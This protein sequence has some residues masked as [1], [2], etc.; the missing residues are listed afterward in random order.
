MGKGGKTNRASP[1]FPSIGIDP[2]ERRA[3]IAEALI[4]G[5]PADAVIAALA[6]DGMSPAAARYEVEKAEKSP[7]LRAGRRAA[8]RLAKRDWTLAIYRRLA[9]TDPA[10][11]TITV[12][13]RIDPARFYADFYHANRPVKL[14]GLISDW[15]ALE[16]WTLDG[17]EARLGH[18]PITLQDRRESSD[19]YELDKDA[20][21]NRVP[22]ADII[23]RLRAGASNDFYVTAYNDGANK[24]VLAPL[25]EDVQPISLLAPTGGLD[26]FFWMGPKGTITP[27]HHD[28]T[29]N[30][31]LQISG[32]KR[33]KMVAAHDG[34]MM[35]NSLHCFSDW[36]GEELPAG[37]GDPARPTV[38]ECDI[39]PG[40]ALFLPV[41]WW[42]HV[43]GLDVTIGMS[44]TNFAAD[45]DFYSDYRTYGPL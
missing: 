28:L 12:V 16:R 33:V 6:A 15:P 8:E 37:P 36:R 1:P 18:V 40:E 7:Y 2:D 13:D 22:L 35:R 44:F 10:Q 9:A 19:R 39:G 38:L 14:T 32:T 25:W 45:N 5:E 4:A 11:A 27:F 30:L 24:R 31:L 29:N 41:G 17:L 26:G 3:A 21:L 34:P 23:A 42:H 43:E 20:H